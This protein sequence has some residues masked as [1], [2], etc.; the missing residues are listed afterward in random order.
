LTNWN[1]FKNPICR[2]AGWIQKLCEYDVEIFNHKGQ[3]N[4]VAD[5]FFSYHR[6]KR[7]RQECQGLL[8]AGSLVQ[9]HLS[10]DRSERFI[11]TKNRLSLKSWSSLS[12]TKLLLYVREDTPH[13][14]LPRVNTLLNT[15]LH[16]CHGSANSGDTGFR[17]TYRHLRT[18]FYWQKMEQTLKEYC[19]RC[20]SCQKNK[21]ST[22]GTLDRHFDG[23]HHC[24]TPESK[25]RRCHGG[26][27]STHENGSF[28]PDK[29]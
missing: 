3:L 15:V 7:I 2:Q 25:S 18:R 24:S 16:E 10:S 11:I 27:L 26:C 22:T 1:A 12:D 8:R 20:D 9:T 14:C 17:K 28:H 5:A 6:F 4:I 29:L 19:K 13:V 21:S 23:I